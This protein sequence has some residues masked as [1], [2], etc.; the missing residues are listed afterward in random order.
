MP[1]C[2]QSDCD[3]ERIGGDERRLHLPEQILR[4]EPLEQVLERKTDANGNCGW[5]RLATRWA[6]RFE[7]EI[8]L[9]RKVLKTQGK[10]CG[11]EQGFEPR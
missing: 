11:W 1:A 2:G 3:E 4:I 9:R 5:N 6:E 10:F 8:T 7:S